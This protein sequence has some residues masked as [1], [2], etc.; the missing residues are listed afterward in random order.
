VE[1][2]YQRLQDD[3]AFEC[4]VDVR[5]L[6]TEYR[7]LP[8]RS[9]STTSATEEP[10][11]GVAAGVAAR[12]L[13]RAAAE[14]ERPEPAPARCAPADVELRFRRWKEKL[15]DL[16]LRNR[17]L[18]FRPDVKAA[19]QLAVPDLELLENGVYAN[20]SFELLPRPDAG[21]RNQRDQTLAEQ[22][23][24]DVADAA[25]LEDLRRCVVHSRHGAEELW[26]R[27]RHLDREARTALEDGGAAVLHLA[28]G[29]LR[30][31]EDGASEEPRLAPLLLYP[32]ELGFDA[33]GRRARMRRLSDDPV[34]NVT[35]VEKLRRDHGADVRDLDGLP[36]A[37]SADD[38]GVAVG[39]LL[40]RFR[41]AIQHIPRWE[42][43]EEAHSACS[44]SR[45]S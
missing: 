4:A 32:V 6:R 13:A 16:T 26:T 12:I 14:A 11:Q 22:R 8:I 43:L 18:N 17:L 23:T 29:F 10:V 33:R 24:Q 1:S 35:L 30:W 25:R 20:R 42:V 28:I 36:M 15:L 2:A 37:D 9:V 27:A 34:L 41:E 38:D 31:Y 21:P 5:A 19:L 44:T 3:A 40:R 7:P 39:E 45:S